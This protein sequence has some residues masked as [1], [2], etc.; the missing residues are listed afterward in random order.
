MSQ[1]FL[2]KKACWIVHGL[3]DLKCS[4]EFKRV[5][6]NSYGFLFNLQRMTRKGFFS[7]RWSENECSATTKYT[8]RKEHRWIDPEVFVHSSVLR[9]VK[10]SGLSPLTHSDTDLYKHTLSSPS[11]RY[12]K[13][14][15][16]HTPTVAHYHKTVTYAEK[17][18]DQLAHDT[19][20][21]LCFKQH[22]LVTNNNVIVLRVPFSSE[23]RHGLDIRRSTGNRCVDTVGKYTRIQPRAWITKAESIVPTSLC[24][25]RIAHAHIE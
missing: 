18:L 19:G 13:T 2:Y 7:K 8:F 17:Q 23:M 21:R 9:L 16:A 5:T 25:T 12:H 11:A 15:R 14:I 20:K 4:D 24:K 22:S 10:S 3:N 6:S 1:R